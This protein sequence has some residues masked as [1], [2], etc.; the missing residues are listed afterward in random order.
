NPRSF[1]N[2]ELFINAAETNGEV[3]LECQYNA[4][5]FQAETVR[6]WLGAYEQLLRGFA[7]SPDR[8][9][10]AI[11]CL[12]PSEYGRIVYEW[13]ATFEEFPRNATLPSLIEAQIARTP[14]RTA[15]ICGQ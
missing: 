2:F 14:D 13:N 3:V 7:E 4:D 15:V 5:L 6:R 12:P 9:L 11:P 1:E 8:A 10:G